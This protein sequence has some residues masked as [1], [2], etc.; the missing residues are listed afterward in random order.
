MK[1]LS[2]SPFQSLP[3]PGLRHRG[4]AI[5]PGVDAYRDW[6]A[7]VRGPSVFL[8]SPPG[9]VPGSASTGTARQVF[10]IPRSHCHLQWEFEAGDKLEDVVKCDAVTPV[11]ATRPDITIDTGRV[12]DAAGAHLRPD[13]SAPPPAAVATPGGGDSPSTPMDRSTSPQGKRR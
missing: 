7:S 6:I 1:L 4:G 11:K 13:P 12:G 9:W 5:V 8:I 2:I 3:M 10:E